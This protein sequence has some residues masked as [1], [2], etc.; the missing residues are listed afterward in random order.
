MC[1]DNFVEVM[2]CE[3]CDSKNSIT[4]ERDKDW[5]ECKAC[6]FWGDLAEY[7]QIINFNEISAL[8]KKGKKG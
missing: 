7:N 5:C 8:D 3:L 4:I 6:G 1:I 2:D